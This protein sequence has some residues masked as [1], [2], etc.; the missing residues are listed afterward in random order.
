MRSNW[1]RTTNDVWHFLFPFAQWVIILFFQVLQV[2]FG[3]ILLSLHLPTFL[4]ICWFIIGL[5]LVWVD[6]VCWLAAKCSQAQSHFKDTTAEC[7]SLIFPTFSLDCFLGQLHLLA[8]NTFLPQKSR[9]CV[10][11][12][13]STAPLLTAFNPIGCTTWWTIDWLMDH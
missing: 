13:L 4:V 7:V 11:A 10:F 6:C 3:H 12:W 5:Y 9:T 2:F 1:I 8:T